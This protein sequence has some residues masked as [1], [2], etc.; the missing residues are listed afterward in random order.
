MTHQFLEA[1]GWKHEVANFVW[2]EILCIKAVFQNTHNKGANC[3]ALLLKHKLANIVYVS[4]WKSSFWPTHLSKVQ[5]FCLR[6]KAGETTMSTARGHAFCSM[7]KFIVLN[8]I[9][10]Q[11]FLSRLSWFGL[12]PLG[13]ML[14]VALMLLDVTLQACTW[15]TAGSFKLTAGYS[16]CNLKTICGFIDIYVDLLIN[17][18]SIEP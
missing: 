15:L 3:E 12:S 6:L 1:L 4:S 2:K 8:T 9:L 10:W 7:T 17:D 16:E 13:M 5:S 11:G 18:C 14:G